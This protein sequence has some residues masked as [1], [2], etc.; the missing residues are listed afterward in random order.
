MEVVTVADSAPKLFTSFADKLIVTSVGTPPS[1]GK[2]TKLQL[3]ILI[4]ELVSLAEPE[5][6]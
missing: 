2:Q 6:I 4:S 5:A 1:C 3:V